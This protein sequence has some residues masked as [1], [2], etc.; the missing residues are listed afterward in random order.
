MKPWPEKWAGK[1]WRARGREFSEKQMRAAYEAIATTPLDGDE[2]PGIL[3]AFGA[4][5]FTDR[6]VDQAMQMMR[7]EG[8]IAWRWTEGRWR[9]ILEVER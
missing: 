3:A 9:W 2:K 1:V 6:R 4:S 5:F 7:K 8:L